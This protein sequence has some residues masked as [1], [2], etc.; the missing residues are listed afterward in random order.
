MKS[1]FF[2]E[3]SKWIGKTCFLVDYFL[4]SFI[5]DIA[6]IIFSLRVLATESARD[7]MP[8]S[9]NIS[10][11]TPYSISLFFSTAWRAFF[12]SKSCINIV[13]WL[14][15]V[16]LPTNTDS[17]W[18]NTE[19]KPWRASASCISWDNLK[20]SALSSLLAR[21]VDA[22]SETIKH[23]NKRDDMKSPTVK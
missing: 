10:S 21:A 1:S 23:V 8:A 16:S 17:D 22:S 20:Y 3:K 4:A 18:L 2:W 7:C 5:K 13:A 6:H 12:V 11:P 9:S 14:K 15:K 19:L